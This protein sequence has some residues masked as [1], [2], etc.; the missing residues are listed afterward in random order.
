M[1]LGLF[2]VFLLPLPIYHLVCFQYSSLG[3][4]RFSV[5]IFLL[6]SL[7]YVTIDT[8]D[9]TLK[10]DEIKCC[11]EGCQVHVYKKNR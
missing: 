2:F 4:C 1:L 11:A 9:D 3:R 7:F 5:L 6:F 10:G 8:R